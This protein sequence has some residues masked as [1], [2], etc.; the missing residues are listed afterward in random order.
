MGELFRQRVEGADGGRFPKRSLGESAGFRLLLLLALTTAAVAIRV[1]W[2]LALLTAVNLVF[3]LALVPRP[4][5]A[6]G[7]A[8]RWFA[9]Q[10]G[11]IVGLYLLRYGIADGLG[12]GAR[13]A[14]QL[15]LV[16]LP[17]AVLARSTPQHRIAATLSRFLPDRAAFVLAVSMR[18]PPI[19]LRE[20]RLL[21][22]VQLLRGARVRPR[23]LLRPVNWPDLAG[24]LL[25]PAV[26]QAL[27]MSSDIAL[28][29]KARDFG[30]SERRTAWPGE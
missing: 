5:A 9:F 4:L 13:T 24:C 22:E 10:T 12:P 30:V 29:A 1:P 6:L 3:L 11:M 18:F 17:G 28:A 7:T 27:A 21:Y 14:W 25:F 26:V 8:L 20:L 16:F 23:D 19:M 2:A 15:F